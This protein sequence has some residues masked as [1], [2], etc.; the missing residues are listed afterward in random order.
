M[1]RTEPE[2]E[3]SAP[4]NLAKKETV[5][6]RGRAR[7]TV[8]RSVE[9]IVPAVAHNVGGEMCVGRYRLTQL[10]ITIPQELVTVLTG[11]VI[12]AAVA[13]V[14]IFVTKE[15]PDLWGAEAEVLRL[16]AVWGT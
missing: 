1:W 16:L 6:P 7:F 10:T 4:H 5:S 8:I 3:R 2:L 15:S 14:V 11:F 12:V 13:L 9:L